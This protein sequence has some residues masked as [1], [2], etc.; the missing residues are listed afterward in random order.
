[1]AAAMMACSQD[2]A[3]SY[4][5]GALGGLM[6]LRLLN[7]SVDG[8]GSSMMGAASGPARFAIP[9]TLALAYNR[10]LYILL[11]KSFLSSHDGVVD[12]KPQK[13]ESSPYGQRYFPV[14]V[15]AWQ[16]KIP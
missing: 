11:C 5:L 2:T 3:A 12:S 4:G 10:C 14:M 13:P 16:S 15:C 9:V 1:M 7:R 6:Y 8:F